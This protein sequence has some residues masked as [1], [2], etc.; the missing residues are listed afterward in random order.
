MREH[1]CGSHG[2][3]GDLGVGRREEAVQKLGV[4]SVLL[5]RCLCLLVGLRILGDL[6]Q[7]RGEQ[8]EMVSR[9]CMGVAKRDG[10]LLGMASGRGQPRAKRKR[11]VL[12]CALHTHASQLACR[13]WSVCSA[14]GEDH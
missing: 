9:H 8:A 5:D 13:L 10:R 3:L 6:R 12:Q 14:G 2:L 4:V 11:P 1:G 7:R